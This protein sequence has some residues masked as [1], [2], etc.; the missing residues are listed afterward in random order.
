MSSKIKRFFFWLK[1]DS[2]VVWVYLWTKLGVFIPDQLYLRVLFRLRMGYW[3]SFR[4]PKRFAE[5]LQWLKLHDRQERFHSMVDKYD[6]KTVIKDLIG[7]EYAIPTLGV[8]NNI[9]EIDYEG[10]PN[11]F[12]LKATFDSGS[13][14]I[15]KNKKDLDK[16]EANKR[17]TK[18]WSQSFYSRRRE[19]P[20][21]GLQ[22][23]IIAEPLLAEPN[24]LL[25]Y[26]FFCFEGEPKW[27]QSCQDRN[28]E[29]GG[30]ILHF[31]NIDGSPLDI[32]DKMHGREIRKEE[33]SAILPKNLDKMLEIARI[34][35]KG[36][37]FLRVDFYEVGEQ[38]YIGEFTFYEAAGFCEFEPDEWNIKMGNWI[39]LTTDKNA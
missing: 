13:Y 36:T 19:W 34:S 9:N 12:I 2:N 10:L 20:Y 14:Y 17:L 22:K 24:E 38:I 4:H 11:S 18:N 39:K 21:K 6:A 37:H 35:S 5:K 29:L 7:K 25:E 3:M 8:W 32:R 30:A 27:F 33:I 31:Y 28:R 23:R 26:K 1:E 16:T 15:C